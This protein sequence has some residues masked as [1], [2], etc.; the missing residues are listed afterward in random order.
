MGHS[1]LR[2]LVHGDEVHA[3]ELNAWIPY[4][5]NPLHCTVQQRRILSLNIWELKHLS[6]IF[7]EVCL[8]PLCVQVAFN[9]FYV[10]PRKE[11]KTNKKNPQKETKKKKTKKQ[12]R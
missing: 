9:L 6:S 10:L 8:Y 3:Y 7:P 2:S 1:L 4:Y 11:K 12:T 5:F